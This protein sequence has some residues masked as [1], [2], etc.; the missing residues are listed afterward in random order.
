MRSVYIVGGLALAY[1]TM[2]ALEGWTIVPDIQNADLVQFTGGADV[3]PHLYGEHTH[4]STSAYLKRDEEEIEIYN[5]A[6]QL[7]LPKAGICRGGQFL[8]VMNG[9]KMYQDVDNHAIKG[10][11]EAYIVGN[12]IPIQ[13]SST[14]HQMMR[15]NTKPEADCHILMTAALSTRKSHMSALGGTRLGLVEHVKGFSHDDRIRYSEAE[16]SPGKTDIEA[17]YYGSTNSLC[18]Q[19]HPEFTGAMFMP[20]RKLY[21]NFIDYYL[22]EDKS[23]EVEKAAISQGNF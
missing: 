20:M 6:N 21:F 22:F 18:F 10:T 5:F 16:G 3:S 19:P 12:L 11:H 8:N 4:A 2:F 1:E 7:G 15:P 14:H 9:G 23:I 13:V 17:L